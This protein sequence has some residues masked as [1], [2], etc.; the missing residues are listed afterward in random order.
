LRKP[1]NAIL[2]GLL[3]QA[4]EELDRVMAYPGFQ[5]QSRQL[6]DNDAH[7]G[8]NSISPMSVTNIRLPVI[9]N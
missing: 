3:A 9:F 1:L 7:C 8:R 5:P 6:V 4:A 2:A